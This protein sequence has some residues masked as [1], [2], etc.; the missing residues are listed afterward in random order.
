NILYYNEEQK[1]ACR[2]FP[3]HIG[4]A[5]HGATFCYKRSWWQNHKFVECLVGEDTG[6]GA[7]ALQA[8]QAVYVDAEQMM[9]IRA[10]GKSDSTTDRGNTCDTAHGMKST[11]IP[12]V[13]LSQIPT[14]FF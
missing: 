3:A 8:Q 2:C 1:F 7:T 9:V 13:P 10:H 14:A 4:R 12:E 11:S 6:F 5:P